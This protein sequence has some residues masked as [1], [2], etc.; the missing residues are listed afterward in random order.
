MVLFFTLGSLTM[1]QGKSNR[2]V[3]IDKESRL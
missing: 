1:V 2:Y 3:D